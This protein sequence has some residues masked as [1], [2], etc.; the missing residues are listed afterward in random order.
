M[1]SSPELDIKSIS[2]I[3][4]KCEPVINYINIDALA[5]KHIR[6]IKHFHIIQNSLCLLLSEETSLGLELRPVYSPQDPEER[7]PEYL[8]NKLVLRCLSSLSLGQAHVLLHLWPRS[9]QQV[10]SVQEIWPPS[11]VMFLT[12]ETGGEQT[13]PTL[14][15]RL[16]LTCQGRLI[17]KYNSFTKLKM[18]LR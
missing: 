1:S 17:R 7:L 16:M 10:W 9:M 14:Y 3:I 2:A 8:E 5:R 18:C 4:S 11:L 6:Y 13:I 15:I 12:P